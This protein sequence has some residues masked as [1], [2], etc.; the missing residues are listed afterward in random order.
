MVRAAPN[1]Q[2][3]AVSQLLFG[4][5]FHVLDAA[6]GWAWGYCGHD[7][8]VGYVQ[9]D[10]LSLPV[11]ATHFVSAREALL[12]ESADIKSPALMTL[13]LGAR[14][15]GEVEGDFLKTASGFIHARHVTPAGQSFDDPVATAARL[16]GA[17][18]LWGG[19]GAGGVDCSGLVQLALALA[20]ID[21]PRDSD[22]QRESVGR[23][24]DAGEPVKHGDLVF[25][26]GHVGFMADESNLLHA[27]AWWMAV[28][29]EPLQ[30]V[31][32]RL[33]PKYEKPILAR[34]RSI[35]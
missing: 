34:R 10:A 22:Q 16:I 32:D 14:L 31:V 8:Y 19:R 11:V 21:C 27:N 18:Y 29:I 28:T 26:P 33:L 30:H 35:S 9:Q 3:A 20:G 12:F 17:P 7:H 4:E 2:A 23:E 5:D 13:S 15:E 25:F 24:L 1:A 6:G